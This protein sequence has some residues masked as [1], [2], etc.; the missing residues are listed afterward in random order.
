MLV[1]GSPRPT[2][3]ARTILSARRK[4]TGRLIRAMP[5]L[6]ALV[7]VKNNHGREFVLYS[8]GHAALN[9]LQPVQSAGSSPYVSRVVLTGML[10]SLTFSAALW[11][12]NPPLSAPSG[13][14]SAFAGLTKSSNPYS[15]VS[16]C[17]VAA[18]SLWSPRRSEKYTMYPLLFHAWA[19]VEPAVG[20][21]PAN[22]WARFVAS[23]ATYPMTP[24]T[25]MPDPEPVSATSRKLPSRV[26]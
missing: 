1:V 25:R 22:H 11:S 8:V 20:M 23:S 26:S 3:P 19:P 24:P 7:D 14:P 15:P 13:A 12:V 16:A 21:A 17:A 2:M 9:T 5:G 4:R 6:P 18:S 10:N